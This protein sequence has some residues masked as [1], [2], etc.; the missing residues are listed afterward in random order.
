MSV[1]KKTVCIPPAQDEFLRNHDISLSRFIQRK[2]REL[3]DNEGGAVTRQDAAPA[4][5]PTTQREEGIDC[6]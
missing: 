5:D 3:M 4:P 1:I 2:L 6:E